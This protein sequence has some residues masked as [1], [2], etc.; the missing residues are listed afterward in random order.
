MKKRFTS[1][2]VLL[3]L[4]ADFTLSAFA[5]ARPSLFSPDNM[6]P[7]STLAAASC[8]QLLSNN[9]A[10]SNLWCFCDDGSVYSYGNLCKIG[11][12]GCEPNPCPP[13]PEGCGG[14]PGN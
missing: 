2:L 9:K 5:I 11:W 1:V 12:Q 4:S 3:L 7:V 6:V 8:R 10:P 14:S 13:A